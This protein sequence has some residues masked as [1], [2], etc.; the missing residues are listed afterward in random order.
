MND[1]PTSGITSWPES[2]RPRERLLAAGE[3]ALTDAELLAILLRV[4]V[5]GQ[6]AVE[7]ARNIVARFGSL[8]AM[9]RADVVQWQEIHGLGTAK[10]AQIKAALELGRRCAMSE[11]TEQRRIGNLEDAKAYASA[12]MRDLATEHLR[13][14]ML[15]R[16]HHLLED[17]LAAQ[18]S[19]HDALVSVREIMTRALRV[20]ASAIILAHNH[21]AGSQDP[22][23]DD[24]ALT[25]QILMST[26]PLEIEFVDHL[27]VTRNAVTSLAERGCLD[28]LWREVFND[29]RQ[30]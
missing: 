17:Y 26:R 15:D 5:K 30:S 8:A 22:S 25:V 21:P 29:A 23:E 14:L 19:V 28:E 6:S 4:G 11:L 16:R 18:G 13:V 12:R 10:I 3:H 2:E 9:A 24:L 20:G 1:R 7:L 27:I